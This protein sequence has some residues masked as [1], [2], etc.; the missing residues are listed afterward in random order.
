V[1][2]GPYFSTALQKVRENWYKLI[3][4]EAR[5]PENKQC[6]VSIEFAILLALRFHFYYNPS[7]KPPGAK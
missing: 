5:A 3:P 1:D 7:K 2:F 4:I 6:R